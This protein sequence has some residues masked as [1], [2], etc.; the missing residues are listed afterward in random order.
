MTRTITPITAGAALSPDNFRLLRAIG[1]PIAQGYG[2]TEVSGLDVLQLEKD[3][4]RSEGSGQPF[5][6]VEVRITEDGEILL[7]GVGVVQGYYKRPEE[8]EKSFKG[9]YF[10]TGDGGYM[11]DE[12][13]FISSTE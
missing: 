9:G 4:Y 6:G 2:S 12:G 10:L 5:P 11:D 13:S 3:Y 7:G 1:V 8:T